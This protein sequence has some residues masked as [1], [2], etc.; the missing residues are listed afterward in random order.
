LHYDYAAL[1]QQHT[2]SDRTVFCH[3]LQVLQSANK[4]PTQIEHYTTRGHHQ[5]N[6]EN[7]STQGNTTQFRTEG[8][9]DTL[10]TLIN[11]NSTSAET[12]K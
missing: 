8:Q 6:R 9:A 7:S 11:K 1:Q 5:H 2:S 10:K 3:N 12:E 4:F